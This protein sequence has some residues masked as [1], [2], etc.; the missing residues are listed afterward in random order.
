MLVLDANILIR[1]V[2][3]NR[4]ISLLDE[5]ADRVEFLAPDT[6]FGEASRKLPIL[7]ER[8]KVRIPPAVETLDLVARFVQKVEIDV[9]SKHEREAR[10]RIDRRDR[11]DWP[12]LATA[13]ALKCPI[14]TEDMDFFGCGVAT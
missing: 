5:Y 12:I 10:E 13:L 7:M 1:A 14:W 3:G 8:R 4:V 9:Y 6:A 11:D 2:L